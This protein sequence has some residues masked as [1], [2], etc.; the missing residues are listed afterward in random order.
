MHNCIQSADSQE[1]ETA[2]RESIMICGSSTK[3]YE[4]EDKFKE[5]MCIHETPNSFNCKTCE[6]IFV[7]SNYNKIK[8][9]GFGQIVLFLLGDPLYMQHIMASYYTNN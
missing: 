1:E 2:L 3:S 4:F 8:V 7:K 6:L 9:C 5:H